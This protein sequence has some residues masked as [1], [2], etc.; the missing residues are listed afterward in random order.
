MRKDD[1]GGVWKG[2]L[3]LGSCD[4]IRLRGIYPHT[5]IKFKTKKE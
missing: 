5:A 2:R 4:I 3:S 1:I